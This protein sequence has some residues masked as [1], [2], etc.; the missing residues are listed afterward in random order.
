MSYALRNWSPH[1]ARGLAVER[2]RHL[3]DNL[4]TLPLVQKANVAMGR[5]DGTTTFHSVRDDAGERFP[6]IYSAWLARGTGTIINR[7]PQLMACMLEE[8]I[9]FEDVMNIETVKVW[10]FET[11]AREYRIRSI[12]LLKLDCE[13]ADCDILQGLIDYCD[14]WPEA[15]P[16]IISFETNGLTSNQVIGRVLS[17]LKVR[18]YGVLYRGRDTVLKYRHAEQ[19]VCCDFLNGYCRNADACYFDHTNKPK[20]GRCCYGDQCTRRHGDVTPLCIVCKRSA[21]Q[22]CCFCYACWQQRSNWDT[23]WLFSG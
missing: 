15:F 7:H 23:P 16:R 21:Q 2:V 6:G 4:A 20:A 19:V 10:S 1:R 3:L 22:N 14:N 12:D 13:G 17:E 18:G 5:W 9:K 11:L 8:G